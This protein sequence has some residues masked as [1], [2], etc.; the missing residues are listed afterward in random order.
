MTQVV[1]QRYTLIQYAMTSSY[2]K[3]YFALATQLIHRRITHMHFR[4]A[5]LREVIDSLQCLILPKSV[6]DA[7][8]LMEPL[9]RGRAHAAH[10]C[11]PVISTSPHLLMRANFSWML[12]RIR[13]SVHLR[14]G[15][16]YFEGDG[17]GDQGLGVRVWKQRLKH[18]SIIGEYHQFF[19]LEGV[20]VDAGKFTNPRTSNP[21][22]PD[23]AIL[24]QL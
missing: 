1:L 8:P 16:R 3:Q 10:P 20:P 17:A 19:R 21:R 23:M 13:V 2:S 6:S 4:H 15:V 12:F 14:H 22:C 9:K 18:P 7:R 24:Q 5:M 11:F